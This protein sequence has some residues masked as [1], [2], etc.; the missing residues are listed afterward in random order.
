MQEFTRR[1]SSLVNDAQEKQIA[2]LE[3]HNLPS[4]ITRAVRLAMAEVFGDFVTAD[5]IDG[6]AMSKIWELLQTAVDR[7]QWLEK[8]T[9]VT[10]PLFTVVL[11]FDDK[12]NGVWTESEVEFSN[13]SQTG[14]DHELSDEEEG[15]FN[16]VVEFYGSGCD[17]KREISGR[18]Y[19]A[20][21][22]H[23]FL[24]GPLRNVCIGT[25][26]FR[27]SRAGLIQFH[28]LLDMADYAGVT[29]DKIGTIS[30][31]ELLELM[32]DRCCRDRDAIDAPYLGVRFDG[33]TITRDGY[34]PA[35]PVEIRSP[36][37]FKIL[38]YIYDAGETGR[39]KSEM[40]A[41]GFT[42]LKQ[43]K[44]KINDQLIP[45]DLR[46]EPGE[47]KLIHKGNQR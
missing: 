26:E 6:Y 11:Y 25:P 43:E 22:W 45:L 5:E 29:P 24:K 31:I 27:R 2:W 34:S 46:F 23:E 36:Q 35:Q 3:S 33:F 42:S 19:I 39:T 17:W 20:Q 18:D 28:E 14:V 41:A 40:E 15:G 37:Q 8:K 4:D 13:P 9:P 7:R 44:T 38:K 1:L 21:W 10:A 32:S 30:L 12:I 16:R 47:H